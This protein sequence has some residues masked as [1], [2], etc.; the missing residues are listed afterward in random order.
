IKDADRTW[1]TDA[2]NVSQRDIHAFVTRK[3]DTRD[4]CHVA[5]LL[6]LALFVLGIYADH[7]HHTLAMDDLALVTNFLYRRSDFHNSPRTLPIDSLISIY[8]SSPI[9]IIWRKLHRHLVAR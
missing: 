2:V 4:T 5:P 7:A 6:S 1:I 9:Q 8:D 3:I